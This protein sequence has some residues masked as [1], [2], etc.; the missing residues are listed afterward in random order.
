MPTAI[1]QM[2]IEGY[3]KFFK[4]RRWEV[5]FRNTRVADY[6]TICGGCDAGEAKVDRTCIARTAIR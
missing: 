4:V 6:G 5:D 3:S 1:G 2:N